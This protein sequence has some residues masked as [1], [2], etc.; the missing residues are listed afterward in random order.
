MPMADLNDV[1]LCYETYG[2]RGDPAIVLIRGLGTQLTE[3]PRALV[4]GLVREGLEVVVFDNR[5]AGLSTQLT[6]ATGKP[7]YRLEDMADDVI[8]LLDHLRIERAHILGISLGGMIAQHVALEHRSRVWSLIS[9]MST[10]GNPDLPP[11]S[12]E[13]R[14]RLI[15]SAATPEALIVLNAENRE[16]FGSPAYPE[17]LDERLA[18][19][20]SAYRRS[21]RPDGV[22][23]QMRAAIADGSRVV[24]LRTLSA[25]T[26]V[27]HGADDPLIP[28]AAGRDTAAVIGG[29][30]LEIIAGMG[31]NIPEAL[32]PR[33]VEIVAAFVRGVPTQRLP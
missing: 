25:P 26:L 2:N 10:T 3:W 29:A 30:Q 18:A 22:A 8:G 11:A 32:A 21:D 16:V 17:S 28:V 23:R 14:A 4:D 24:R 13:I 20:R 12:P 6:D 9:V 33:I 1:S 7:P 15:E 31:H 27:I 19:A 5:D